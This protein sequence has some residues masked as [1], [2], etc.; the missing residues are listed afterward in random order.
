MADPSPAVLPTAAPLVPAVTRVRDADSFLGTVRYVGPVA[1]ARAA[2]EVYVGVEWDD[3]TRGRHDGSVI[4]RRTGALVRHFSCRG[5]GG[6]RGS[7]GYGHRGWGEEEGNGERNGE[8]GEDGIGAA[9]APPPSS[10]SSSSS[11]SSFPS[12]AGGLPSG[13]TG[14]DAAA[15]LAP[16]A[17]S[18][19]RLSRRDVDW[20]T[21]AAL[22]LA[23]LR[24]RYV[25]EG[26]ALVAPGGSLPHHAL[27]SSGRAK[28]IELVG[29]L[30]IRSR[31]QPGGDGPGGG[32]GG[33]GRGLTGASLRSMGISAPPPRGPADVAEFAGLEELDLAGNLLSDW[34]DVVAILRCFPRLRRVGLAGNRL[35]DVRR[36]DWEEAVGGGGRSA[37]SASASAPTS[38]STSAA[39][40]E[41]PGVRVLNLNSTGMRTY[42]TAEWAAALMPNLEELCLAHSALGGMGDP[43][44]GFGTEGG[45]SPG[46]DPVPGLERLRLL[47]LTGCGLGAGD[48]RRFRALPSLAD[49]ILDGNDMDGLRFP[50]VGE[51]EGGGER[52]DG[53]GD[54]GGG[55]GGGEPHF[56]SLTSLH[57]TRCGIGSWA[58]LD[59]VAAGL[60]SVRSLRFRHNPVSEDLSPA[61]A[62]AVAIARIPGLEALNG[63][64]VP[65]KER[66]E[67]ERRYVAGVARELLLAETERRAAAA[68]DEGDGEGEGT[69]G[70]D[71]DDDGGAGSE[72][73]DRILGRHPLFA[74]LL[75]KHRDAMA[76][77]AAAGLGPGGAGTGA[78][79]HGASNVTLRSMAASSCSAEPLTRRLPGTLTVGRVKVLCQRAFGLDVDLQSLHVRDGGSDQAFPTELDDDENPLSY[80]GVTDGSEIL[81]NEIDF[82]ADRREEERAMRRQEERIGEQER[83]ATALQAAQTRGFDVSAAAGEG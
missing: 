12:P 2:S 32:G 35:G 13:A 17:G 44:F 28:P 42:R 82:E 56:P 23:T 24:S 76:A 47:D 48:V 34:G 41:F 70:G 59:S 21:G 49:L 55:G 36:G 4:C 51:Q 7:G 79:A 31:Q 11:S 78:L 5:R 71:A 3:G 14:A 8:S 58:P 6:R 20:D 53:S 75:E 18:F 9:K 67:S 45:G 38:T 60:P 74:S 81:M 25:T 1:S 52:G 30:Q 19:L 39:R 22:S 46:G 33:R 77:S 83:A 62:R 29:E 54:G 57:L 15:L 73:R 72:E 26:S 68:G 50:P 64:P 65:P 43:D 10:S 66:K 37:P 80:Y 69:A 16:T 63:S 40:A 61:E 27:T